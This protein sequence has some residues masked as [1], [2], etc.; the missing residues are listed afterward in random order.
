M[1]MRIGEA[2]A[3][4]RRS[5]VGR[6]LLRA[7]RTAAPSGTHQRRRVYAADALSRLAVVLHARAIGFSIAETRRLVG[8]FPTGAPSAR[9]KALAAAKLDAM[10]ALIGRAR[11]MKSMLQLISSCRC[12]SWGECGERLLAKLGLPVLRHRCVRPERAGATTSPSSSSSVMLT[13]SSR[14]SR[15]AALAVRLS[16]TARSRSQSTPDG[17]RRRW[18]ARA[19]HQP[20]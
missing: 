18:G 8:T 19:P 9:W 20:S 13:G 17:D 10:D 14:P 11:A 4:R 16:R 3:A 1:S 7:G 6:A 15:A 12:K 5:T 2:G